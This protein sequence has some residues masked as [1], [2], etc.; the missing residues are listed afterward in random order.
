LACFL[1]NLLELAL[2]GSILALL[3]PRCSPPA[4]SK[5]DILFDH[6]GAVFR[7]G[8]PQVRGGGGCAAVAAYEGL[9][10][11]GIM[12]LIVA[13]LVG[14]ITPKAVDDHKDG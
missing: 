14:Q 12:L 6:L 1:V 7:L 4:A 8:T 9:V 2:Y 10:A 13:S 11:G 3:F 5:V